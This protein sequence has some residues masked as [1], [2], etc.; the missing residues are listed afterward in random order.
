MLKHV[1]TSSPSLTV[2]PAS[3]PLWLS[4]PC[5]L[6]SPSVWMNHRQ[7]PLASSPDFL[8]VFLLLTFSQIPP[9]LKEDA[10]QLQ[11]LYKSCVRLRSRFKTAILL[12]ILSRSS[13]PAESFAQGI[14]FRHHSAW[15]SLRLS[16]LIIAS[17]RNYLLR[18]CNKDF[19]FHF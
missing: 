9:L 16:V 7:R 14:G 15:F 3:K 6:S 1:L 17:G 4:S 8:F 2:W 13:Q 11:P 5:L 12:R 18:S 19:T 10:N